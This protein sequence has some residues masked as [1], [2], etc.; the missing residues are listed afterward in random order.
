MNCNTKDD[1]PGALRV[2]ALRV[3]AY[4]AKHAGSITGFILGAG[5][6]GKGKPRSGKELF[7][8]A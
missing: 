2:D 4:F 7:M 6:G 3:E 5:A 1:R 8:P